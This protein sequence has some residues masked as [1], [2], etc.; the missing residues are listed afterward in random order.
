[1]D[2][3][4]RQEHQQGLGKGSK[5]TNI[6]ISSQMRARLLDFAVRLVE[7]RGCLLRQHRSSNGSKTQYIVNFLFEG[8]CLL[9]HC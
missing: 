9:R 6:R 4:C 7:G 1:M 8:V 5:R 2:G 3:S